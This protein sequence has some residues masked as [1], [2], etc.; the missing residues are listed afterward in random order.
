MTTEPVVLRYEAD[1]GATEG[2][3]RWRRKP[4]V[5]HAERQAVPFEV[6]TPGGVSSGRA[7]DWLVVGPAGEL[8]PL[9]HE[10]FVAAYEPVS[11]P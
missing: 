10:V 8:Y 7:G 2:M 9:R 11:G 4:V 5:V 6:V 1:A 3:D